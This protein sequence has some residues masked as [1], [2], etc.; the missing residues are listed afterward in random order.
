METQTQVTPEPIFQLASGFM[1]SKLF[2]AANEAGVFEALSGGPKTVDAIAGDCGRPAWTVGILADAMVALH[3]LE[4]EDG[5]YRNGAIADT[6]L[7]G[8]TPADLR[9]FLR[10]WNTISYPRW[11]YLD[12]C[13]SSASAAKGDFTMT[14]E[15]QRIF[16]EGVAAVTAGAA[17]ALAATYDFSGRTKVLDL[18]GGT[19]FF[20]AMI[21]ERYTGLRGTLYEEPDVVEIAKRHLGS[22]GDRIDFVSGNFMSDELPGGHDVILAANV[23][24]YFSPQGNQQLLK[25]LRETAAP[26][27]ALLM[28]D[29][30]MNAEHTEPVA[31]ALMSG[32]FLVNL[33]DGKSYSV[34]EAREWCD[35]TGWRVVK[36]V[37]LAGPQSLVVMQPA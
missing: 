30:W 10:F 23:V 14:P 7:A 4:R 24:H 35:V 27:A 20:L 13:V 12:E 16:S 8:K 3:M 21:L 32:E 6:F 1:A 31:A 28:V 34:D 2:F 25:R 9:P 37:G 33:G 11:Q 26:D 18:G 22:F 15:Q 36:H 5:L 19:G 29:F 17:M